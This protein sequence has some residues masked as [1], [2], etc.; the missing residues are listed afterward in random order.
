MLSGRSGLKE[1]ASVESPGPNPSNDGDW[2]CFHRLRNHR[3]MKEQQR[4]RKLSGWE[5]G[6][7]SERITHT[8]W[9]RIRKCYALFLGL[10]IHLFDDVQRI[11]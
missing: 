1:L 8:C 2:R 5:S 7:T 6:A 3:H 11:N 10:W 4:N 9:S